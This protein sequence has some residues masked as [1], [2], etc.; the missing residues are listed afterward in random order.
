MKKLIQSW[1]S[2]NNK[3]REHDK[4]EELDTK[5]ENGINFAI[6][7]YGGTLKDLARYD[8]GEKLIH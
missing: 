3:K 6:E 8:R 5:V 2:D 7:K 4:K 1:F